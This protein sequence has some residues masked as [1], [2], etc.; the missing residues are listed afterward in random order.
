[1]HGD[2]CLRD[3]AAIS[4][5]AIGDDESLVARYGGEEFAVL[6]PDCDLRNA[7]RIGERLRRCIDE[8]ALPHPT[9]L[10]TDHVTVSIGISAVRARA[11]LPCEMLIDAADRALYRA[12]DLGRNCVVARSVAAGR[13]IN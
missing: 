3:L 4:I 6:L 7:R 1:M 5:E 13:A 9:S 12:K 11:S 8:I 10:V 2:E